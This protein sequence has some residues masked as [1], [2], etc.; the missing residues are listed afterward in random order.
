MSN[1]QFDKG[2]TIHWKMAFC[3]A[4]NQCEIALGTCLF[5]TWPPSPCKDIVQWTYPII[6]Y[7]IVTRL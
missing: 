1:I 7:L 4:R 2:M 5:P 3:R 6:F